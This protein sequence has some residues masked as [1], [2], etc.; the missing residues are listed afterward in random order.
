MSSS[1]STSRI[2]PLGAE[3]SDHARARLRTFTT[4]GGATV[5]VRD[6]DECPG[7]CSARLAGAPS[8]RNRVFGRARIVTVPP[9]PSQGDRVGRERRDDAA[10]DRDGHLAER[11]RR[12][13]RDRLALC[14]TVATKP[15]RMS[16]SVPRAPLTRTRV[17]GPDGE[18][19][20]RAVQLAQRDLRRRDRLHDAA[21]RDHLAAPGYCERR[22]REREQRHD[23]DEEAHCTR[24]SWAHSRSPALAH[25]G[26]CVNRM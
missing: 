25:R 21:V 4:A 2:V 10:V 1:S 17:A 20:E 12:R 5:R 14:R 7:P 9:P 8:R 11:A 22:Q 15:G 19:D 24:A 18:G 16:A 26:A 23:D 13:G 3:R 6:G